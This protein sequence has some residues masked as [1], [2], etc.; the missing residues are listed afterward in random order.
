MADSNHIIC[1]HFSVVLGQDNLKYMQVVA[2]FKQLNMDLELE[3]NLN[4][5]LD[6]ISSL[7]TL[8]GKV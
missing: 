8:Q 2:N 1:F 3:D 6:S 5:L 7:D 4:K